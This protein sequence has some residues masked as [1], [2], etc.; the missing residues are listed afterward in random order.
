MA[1]ANDSGGR[2]KD[3]TSDLLH[4]K[5]ALLPLRYAPDWCP[6]T[7]SNRRMSGC[8]PDAFAAW[9]TGRKWSERQESNL[10]YPGPKP[11]DQPLTHARMASPDGAYP[12]RSG[13]GIQT[14]VAGG[15]KNSDAGPPR[16]S[17]K[18]T[19]AARLPAL[20]GAETGALDGLR[21]RLH[22]L[23]RRRQSQIATNARFVVPDCSRTY[24]RHDGRAR[25]R[26]I[27]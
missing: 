11:G 19:E 16:R 23:D 25:Q 27:W 6:V 5:Q 14:P 2:G 22:P 21:S 18:G 4:V 12:S 24:A 9:R 7:D 1:Q 10:P 20:R 26:D 3:R 17:C 13:L 15:D 8:R